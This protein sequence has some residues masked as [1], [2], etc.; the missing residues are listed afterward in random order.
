MHHTRGVYDNG[1]QAGL[2]I[3]DQSGNKG[4]EFAFSN[5]S[6]RN[7]RILN[8]AS[9]DI[10]FNIGSGQN[11]TDRNVA[12]LDASGNLGLLDDD[13]QAKLSIVEYDTGINDDIVDIRRID[14]TN[15]PLL[16]IKNR[17]KIGVNTRYPTY[18][19]SVSGEINESGNHLETHGGVFAQNYVYQTERYDPF[20]QDNWNKQNVEIDFNAKSYRNIDLTGAYEVNFSTKNGSESNDEVKSVSVKLFS[21]GASRYFT[22]DKSSDHKLIE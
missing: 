19:L 7:L 16:F 3:Y 14:N 17:G 13:P 21:S 5:G 4:G 20:K 10:K 1:F 12:V 22:F 8:L 15:E 11:L 9:G 18:T 6:D 2:F